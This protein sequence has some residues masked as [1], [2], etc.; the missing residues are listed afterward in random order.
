MKRR[1]GRNVVELFC[2]PEGGGKGEEVNGGVFFFVFFLGGLTWIFC[3]SS[4]RI[5][6]A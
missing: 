6:A 4:C 3:I 1:G 5:N 2:G